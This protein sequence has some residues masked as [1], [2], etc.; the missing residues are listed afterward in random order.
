MEAIKRHCAVYFGATGGT[1]VLL[2]RSVVSVEM[3]AYEDL[4]PEAVL[5]LGIREMPLVV[6]ADCH[7]GDIYV[8]GPE[9]AMKLIQANN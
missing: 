3:V 2:S 1:A 4:G 9:E 5:R 6:L 8:S 7:G